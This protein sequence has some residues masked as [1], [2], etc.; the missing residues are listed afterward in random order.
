MIKRSLKIAA[1]TGA[2]I[3][4]GA[5]PALATITYPAEGGEWDHGAGTAMVWSDYLHPS[6]CHGSTSV[7]TYTDTDTASAGSWS[8]TGAPVM[9]SGNKAYYKTTC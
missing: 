9:L 6:K 5:A 4:A 1:V 3:V 8:M 7:G 2:L